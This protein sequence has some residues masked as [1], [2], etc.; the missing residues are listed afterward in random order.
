MLLFERDSFCEY[1][2]GLIGRFVVT[3]C[4]LKKFCLSKLFTFLFQVVE[5]KMQET[6]KIIDSDSP[7]LEPLDEPIEMRAP[8]GAVWDWFLMFSSLGLYSSFWLYRRAK[9]LRQ[10]TSFQFKP[11]LWFFVPL[12]AISQP[13]AYGKMNS[14]LKEIEEG[15]KE[16]GRNRKLYVIGAVAFF[17]TSIY[18]SASTGWVVAGWVDALGYLLITSGFT[19]MAH[20]VNK[21]KAALSNVTFKGERSGYT[22]WEWLLVIVMFPVLAGSFAFD[23]FSL[24]MLDKL[25]HFPEG[26]YYRSQNHDF[27]FWF[28]GGD[29]YSMPVGTYSDGGA[30]AEFGNDVPESYFIVFGNEALNDDEL[31]DHI[32]SRKS[33]IQET[34]SDADCE[35]K[36]SFEPYSMNVKVE[37]SC[38][39]EIFLD[40][41]SAFVTYIKTEKQDYELL[42]VLTGPSKS[43]Q[44]W[45][46]AYKE[47]AG[48]F[49]SK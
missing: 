49:S 47:M 9:E 38:K 33:W 48:E 29:W 14:A 34:I 41:A 45:I 35:E 3:C 26:H 19:L 10:V 17:L 37:L 5:L 6:S 8:R 16:T 4:F 2:I 15:G 21:A 27:R 44:R 36:R 28:R 11:I 13:F 39:G 24:L 40:P 30:L 42:G 22:I 18:F 12:I 1:G 23:A 7:A 32:D 20:R 25:E 31:N 43:Y 46:R